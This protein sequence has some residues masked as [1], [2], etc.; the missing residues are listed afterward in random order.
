MR[1][2]MRVALDFW[3]WERLTGEGIDDEAAAELM[4]ERRRGRVCRCSALLPVEL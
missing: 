1:S 2:L 3:T 4:T